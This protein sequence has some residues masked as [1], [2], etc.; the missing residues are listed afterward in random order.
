MLLLTAC[1]GMSRNAVWLTLLE[2]RSTDMAR[3]QFLRSMGIRTLLIVRIWVT[4]LSSS[5]ITR[6]F[7]MMW[8]LSCTLWL[9]RMMRRDPIL[10]DISQRRRS[11]L[12]VTI[13]LVFWPCLSIRERGME[14]SWLHSLMS[15]Q[16]LRRRLV[17]QRDLSQIWV[18]KVMCLGGLRSLLSSSNQIEI[19]SILSWILSR[20]L[21]SMRRTSSICWRDSIWSNIIRATTIYVLMTRF[22]TC[23]SRLQEDQE[24]LLSVRR[25]NGLHLD[26]NMIRFSSEG[27]YLSAREILSFYLSIHIVHCSIFFSK[28]RNTIKKALSYCSWWEYTYIYVWE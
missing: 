9:L 21:W 11:H 12:M 14:S 3:I 22:L 23:F 13:S 26:L 8:S 20:A 1:L 15:F 5:W 6:P 19:K 25:Y 4:L 27:M 2:M 24:S 17:L 16:Q 10:S 18:E 7:T 28:L